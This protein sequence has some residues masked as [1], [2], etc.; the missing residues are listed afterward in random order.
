M[1]IQA[2][3]WALLG[4]V[5]ASVIAGCIIATLLDKTVGKQTKINLIEGW[6]KYMV[7]LA[8]RKF[9]S[10]TGKLKLTYV[11]NQFVEKW[12]DIAAWMSESQFNDL[13]NNAVK[14]ME[15]LRRNEAI[16]NFINNFG[17]T[18]LENEDYQGE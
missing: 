2:N 15:E 18:M 16:N 12:P 3:L 5:A 17:L 7:I 10:G 1:L 13:V 14:K 6:L 11:Y 8:E 9:G 4:I